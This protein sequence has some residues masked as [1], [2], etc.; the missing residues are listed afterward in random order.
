MKLFNLF[1]SLLR[2]CPQWIPSALTLL[3]ILWLTLA[4]DPTPELSFQLFAGADKIVHA[5]M[6]GFLSL[7]MWFD[8]GRSKHIWHMPKRN[9]AA[10]CAVSS[11]AAGIIIE[12]LQHVM[13]LGRG[14]EWGDIYADAT[15]ALL[16][17]VLTLNVSNSN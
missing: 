7:I 17:F 12:C 5:I 11:L 9:T 15:G 3:F 14:F 10:I 2:W 6:F 4:P 13:G 16:A 1:T 8:A